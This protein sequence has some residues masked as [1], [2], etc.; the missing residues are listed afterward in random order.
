VL[1]LAFALGVPGL[2]GHDFP[3][4]TTTLVFLDRSVVDAAV[5]DRGSLRTLS[6]PGGL[7]LYVWQGAPP[8]CCLNGL[9]LDPDAFSPDGGTEHAQPA[10]QPG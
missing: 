6:L 1:V 7:R 9:R 8:T 3:P 5:A 4:G 10:P 2:L